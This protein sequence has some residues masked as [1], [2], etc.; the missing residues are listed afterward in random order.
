MPVIANSF[1]NVESVVDMQ[2]K[3]DS[4]KANNMLSLNCL[5]VSHE[6]SDFNRDRNI[7]QAELRISTST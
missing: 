5:P 6:S 7:H 4:R 2:V 1:T 3:T